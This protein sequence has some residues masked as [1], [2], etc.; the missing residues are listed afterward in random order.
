MN[1]KN[2]EKI[3]K[4]KDE[5]KKRKQIKGFILGSDECWKTSI[6]TAGTVIYSDEAN[7]NGIKQSQSNCKSFL[8]NSAGKTPS[9]EANKYGICSTQ[10]RGKKKYNAFIISNMASPIAA[11]TLL[12][13][14]NCTY[15]WL[16]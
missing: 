12:Y 1:T 2:N 5:K 10:S 6:K 16:R 15:R 9:C 7:V 4:V 11:I 13:Q 8:S 3:M 14:L